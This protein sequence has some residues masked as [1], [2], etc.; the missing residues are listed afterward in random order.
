MA[1]DDITLTRDLFLRLLDLA[2]DTVG[3]ERGF[4]EDEVHDLRIAAG[5][6]GLDPD[7]VTPTWHLCRITMEHAWTPLP[8]RSV[9]AGRAVLDWA[10]SSGVS[11]S[12]DDIRRL[13]SK[14]VELDTPADFRYCARCGG[15]AG[16]PPPALT[17]VV[18][19]SALDLG[20]VKGP[21]PRG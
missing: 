12:A 21:A 1:M 7:C 10:A 2:A 5:L 14:T 17:V 18:H 13:I 8:S 11:L 19:Q 3:D 20:L 4:D 6:A 15:T 9:S 16:N